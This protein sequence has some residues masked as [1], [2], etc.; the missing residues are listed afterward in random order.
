[1]KACP[2][3]G[4]LYP[5]DAGFC[6]VEGT[7]LTRV[8]RVPVLPAADARV[9]QALGSRYQIRRV[10]ADGGIGRVYEALDLAEGRSVAVKVLHPAV[11]TDPVQIERFEREFATSRALAHERVVEVLDFIAIGSDERALMMELLYG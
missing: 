5:E 1:M 2:S 3:C 4:R 10:I 9:G 8:S 11:A 6:P 7:G